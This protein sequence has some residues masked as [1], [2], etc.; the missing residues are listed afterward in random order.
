MYSSGDATL[1]LFYNGFCVEQTYP[2]S[3]HIMKVSFCYSVKL[4]KDKFYIFVT[5]IIAI[6]SNDNSNVVWCAA[7]E[8]IDL[9]TT[10]F[11]G[12]IDKIIDGI[13]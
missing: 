2:E 9:I 1:V 7:Q 3:F 6:I 12:V 8:N 5:E 4:I 13:F 11:Y 10:I